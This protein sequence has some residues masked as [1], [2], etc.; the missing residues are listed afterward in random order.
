M[1]KLRIGQF[2]TV[3]SDVGVIIG[4]PNN[5]QIPEDHLAIWYGQTTNDSEKTV[6]RVRTVP[7]E[8]CIPL[9]EISF[10]H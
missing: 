5:S 7:K 1:E 10:Y 9:E 2:V 4:F 3:G 6:P 8:Y